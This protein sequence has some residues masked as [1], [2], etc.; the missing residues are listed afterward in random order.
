MALIHYNDL[1]PCVDIDDETYNNNLARQIADIVTV[2]PTAYECIDMEHIV[3]CVNCIRDVLAL[4]RDHP[5]QE[6]PDPNLDYIQCSVRWSH[7]L[8]SEVSE[9]VAWHQDMKKIIEN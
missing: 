6:R 1:Y 8:E 4:E 7:F 2:E 3:D 9:I 5:I